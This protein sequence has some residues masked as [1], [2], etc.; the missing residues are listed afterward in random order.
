MTLLALFLTP[1]TNTSS[2]TVPV[3]PLNWGGRG[4]E[5]A[6]VKCYPMHCICQIREQVRRAHRYTYNDSPRA[7]HV[8]GLVGAGGEGADGTGHSPDKAKLPSY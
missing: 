5:K 7:L 6:M 3:F 4:R 8:D 2:S 1:G